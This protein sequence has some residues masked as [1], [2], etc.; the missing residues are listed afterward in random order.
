MGQPLKKE[1]DR[2]SGW[3]VNIDTVREASRKASRTID[4]LTDKLSQE[5]GHEVSK[6]EADKAR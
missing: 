5:I 6:E 4:N 3:P 2:P 1:P